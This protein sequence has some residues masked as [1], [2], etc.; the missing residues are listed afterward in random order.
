[1]PLLATFGR[2]AVLL[3]QLAPWRS[4]RCLIP[5][6]VLCGC[7]SLFAHDTVQVSLPDG[8][9]QLLKAKNILIATGGA[10]S[11]LDIE[12]AEH[13]ITSDEALALENLPDK[14]VLIVG[15]G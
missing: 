14:S 8:S 1:M 11:K 12:G 5:F 3:Q 15:S 7:L 4:E 6:A 13:A 10:P 2:A 9:E